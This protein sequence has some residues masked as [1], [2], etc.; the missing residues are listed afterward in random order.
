MIALHLSEQ[1]AV[2]LRNL[3]HIAVQAGGMPAAEIAVPID[4][5]IREAGARLEDAK[6]RVRQLEA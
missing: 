5:R 2:A 4:A 3:L 1:E 6:A